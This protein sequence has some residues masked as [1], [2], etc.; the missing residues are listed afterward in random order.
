MNITKIIKSDYVL[1]NYS[2]DIVYVIIRRLK[3][4][5]YICECKCSDDLQ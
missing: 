5:G 3:D 4:M 2:F 1:S